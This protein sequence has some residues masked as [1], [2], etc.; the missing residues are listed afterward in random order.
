M[1]EHINESLLEPFSNEEWWT[2]THGHRSGLKT[3]INE[4]EITNVELKELPLSVM[5]KVKKPRPEPKIKLTITLNENKNTPDGGI[6]E[7]QTISTLY[8]CHRGIF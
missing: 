3:T 6:I 8:K 4:D 5:D 2:E 1:D 7:K